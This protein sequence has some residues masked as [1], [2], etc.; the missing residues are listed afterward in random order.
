MIRRNDRADLAR[1]K[2][3]LV[4]GKGYATAAGPRA[5]AILRLA[6]PRGTLTFLSNLA[7][8]GALSGFRVQHTRPSGERRMAS[9]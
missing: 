2:H 7:L 6:R 1:R 3:W 8:V 9:I 4:T 5:V